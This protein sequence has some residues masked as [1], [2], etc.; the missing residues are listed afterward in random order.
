ML[1]R[2]SLLVGTLLGRVRRRSTRIPLA[3]AL[4]L[5]LIIYSVPV[6]PGAVSLTQLSSDP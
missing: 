5:T 4:A 2:R 3:L 6:A 1:V